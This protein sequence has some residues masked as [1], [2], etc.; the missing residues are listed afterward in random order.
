M[1]ISL[2]KNVPIVTLHTIAVDPVPGP[3]GAVTVRGAW[4]QT[5]VISWKFQ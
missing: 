3:A 2:C 1:M 5:V 4:N